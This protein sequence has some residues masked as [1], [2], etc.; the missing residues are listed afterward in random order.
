[1]A[2]RRRKKKQQDDEK[3]IDILEATDQA[4]TFYEKNQNLILGVL[5]IAVL[6]FGG[7]FAYNTFYKAP[8]NEE[9]I[10]QMSQAQIMFERDS[11]QQALVN[12]GGGFSGF[13]DIAEDYKGTNAGN[14]ALYYA[15][16]CYLNIGDYGIALDYLDDFDPAG[17]IAPIMKYG[18]MGDAFSEIDQFDNALK[19]YK[20]AVNQSDNEL[21]VPYYLK[22]IGLLHEKQGNFAEAKTF[23]ERIK[24]EYPDSP[25]RAGIEKYITRV[26]NKG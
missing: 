14:L 25:D 17:T 10:R 18:A 1:M 12:P 5:T 6:I 8:R 4:Q 24:N 22:K 21:L 26:D 16:I 7:L 13:V 9:A 20:R 2:Q 3:L 11:F 23:Y 19:Y 15:G